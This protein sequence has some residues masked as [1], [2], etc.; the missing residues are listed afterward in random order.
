MIE[1]IPS[2]GY[3]RTR[4][5]NDGGWTNE[6][7]RSPEGVADFDW[8][9]SQADIESDGPFSTF[10]DCE[11]ELIV[12]SGGA[13][14]HFAE[15]EQVIDLRRPLDR[16]RFSGRRAVL[17]EV[18]HQPMRDL[19]IIWRPESANVDVQTIEIAG[20]HTVPVRAITA[21][22]LYVASGSLVATRGKHEI[23]L[24]QDDTLK[25]AGQHDGGRT[26]GPDESIVLTGHAKVISIAITDSERV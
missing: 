19:N 1:L 26:S 10:E 21:L 2:P 7:A 20:E 23:S 9:L 8:R 24:E 18:T 16:Y 14:L 22:L 13:R 25:V 6:I 3:R 11:R 15:P 12:L 5:V 17:A 4:W